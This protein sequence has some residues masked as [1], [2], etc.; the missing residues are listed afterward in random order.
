MG[1]NVAVM[2]KQTPDYH[3][4]LLRLWRVRGGGACSS[5]E[6]PVWRASLDHPLSGER[7]GFASLDDLVAY[8]RQQ[9]GAMPDTDGGEG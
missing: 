9:M 3:S 2:D 8:L 6:E 5:H 4:Y 7:L 1:A